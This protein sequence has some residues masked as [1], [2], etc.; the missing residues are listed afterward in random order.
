TLSLIGVGD[1]DSRQ[2]PLPERHSSEAH[3]AGVIDIP[4]LIALQAAARPW[5][6][7]Q[8]SV[9]GRRS[10]PLQVVLILTNLLPES[11]RIPLFHALDAKA[12]AAAHVLHIAATRAS[13]K[14]IAVTLTHVGHVHSQHPGQPVP[15][16]R[17]DISQGSQCAPDRIFVLRKSGVVE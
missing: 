2:W 12:I 17:G 3:H 8:K 1:A 9:D 10:A 15:V 13:F 4:L 14:R 16:A 5:Y 6:G 11:A 7:S